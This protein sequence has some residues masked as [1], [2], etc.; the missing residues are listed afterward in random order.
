MN[1]SSVKLKAPRR[2]ECRAPDCA[3]IR[4]ICADAKP[5]IDALGL[6]PL[7]IQLDSLAAATG[8]GLEVIDIRTAAEFAASPSVGRHIDMPALLADPGALQ[9]GREFLLV[10]AS[11]RRSLAA[12][13]ELRKRG[14]AVRSLAG[15]LGALRA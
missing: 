2:T 15:G 5:E 14:I 11:G 9:R 1:F 10:C 12:A 4:K 13:R 7:E 8:Q 6:D 3:R